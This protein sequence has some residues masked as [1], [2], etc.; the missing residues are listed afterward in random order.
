MAVFYDCFSYVLLAIHVF[1][2]LCF[3]HAQGEQKVTFY[4]LISPILT[5]QKNNHIIRKLT[6]SILT[7]RETFHEIYSALFVYG[8]SC[9]DAKKLFADIKGL[10]LSI[11]QPKVLDF[12]KEN[13]G[14]VQKGIAKGCHVE[15]ASL[16]TILTG[17][18]KMG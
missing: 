11:G 9:H 16:S 7:R 13:D 14:A 8:K 2:F 18:E 4:F 5:N 12:L 15:L 6:I 1:H 10:G 17:M 3:K